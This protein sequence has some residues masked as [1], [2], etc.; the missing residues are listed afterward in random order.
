[1]L[2]NILNLEN[3]SEISKKEQRKLNGGEDGYF[4]P[5]S[6]RDCS[7]CGGSFSLSNNLCF[8]PFT[9]PCTIYG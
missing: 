4:F 9:S 6:A 7:F 5:Y 1:M 8:V 3:T 2:K